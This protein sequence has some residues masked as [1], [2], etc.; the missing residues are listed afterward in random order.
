M[1]SQLAAAGKVKK[2]FAHCLDSITGGGIFAIGDV[3][4]PKVKTTPVVPHQYVFWLQL[5]FVVICIHFQIAQLII[6]SYF[7]PSLKSLVKIL[8]LIEGI[9]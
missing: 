5:L 7:V 2:I 8:K 4:E 1:I 3:V 9:R 6:Q